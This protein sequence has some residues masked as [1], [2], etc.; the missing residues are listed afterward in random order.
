[1]LHLLEIFC[2][3]SKRGKHIW[4]RS[5]CSSPSRP[6]P[7]LDRGRTG[8]CSRKRVRSFPGAT[9]H[10][11]HRSIRNRHN[12]RS[13]CIRSSAIKYTGRSNVRIFSF[14]NTI[15]GLFLDDHAII[16]TSIHC[17][18]L[19]CV[20]FWREHRRR[21]HSWLQQTNTKLAAV[22]AID[23]FVR[24]SAAIPVT[25]PKRTRSVRRAQ[26]SHHPHSDL[27][28]VHSKS[29]KGGDPSRPYSNHPIESDICKS[30]STER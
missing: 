11:N 4:K 6:Q 18:E 25:A 27:K 9:Y 17:G 24:S 26:Q 1:M 21:E 29:C 19:K 15:T 7:R 12:P 23:F 14:S 5:E 13:L 30:R 3:H 10:H 8:T 20:E 2:Q 28:S 22:S 16:A